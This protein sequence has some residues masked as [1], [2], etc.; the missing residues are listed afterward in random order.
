MKSGMQRARESLIWSLIQGNVFHIPNLGLVAEKA[1]RVFL[2]GSV[3]VPIICDWWYCYFRPLPRAQRRRLA[4]CFYFSLSQVW[5][6]FHSKAGESTSPQP[7]GPEQS[8]GQARRVMARRLCFL[9][10]T[11]NRGEITR[12]RLPVKGQRLL[13]FGSN[14][15]RVLTK[16]HG[17][18][19]SL[20]SLVEISLQ[21]F[22]LRA[23]ESALNVGM[24]LLPLLHF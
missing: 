2:L 24:S 17:K 9:L 5:L 8:T 12:E 10:S 11:P 3:K 1:I 22:F 14:Q 21:T 4:G 16:V 7:C 23:G 19:W 6:D 15:C 20:I 18:L 13:Y